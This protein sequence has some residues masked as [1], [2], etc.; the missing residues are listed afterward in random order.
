MTELAQFYTAKVTDFLK[1]VVCFDDKAEYGPVGKQRLFA[2]TQDDG[3]SESTSTSSSITSVNQRADN[4]DI[5]IGLNAQALTHAFAEKAILCSVIKPHGANEHI[6]NQIVSLGKTADVLILDWKLAERDASI[7]RDAVIK[8][9]DDDEKGGGRL[10]LIVLY[11]I[12]KGKDVIKELFDYL[13]ERGYS[14][15]EESLEIKNKHTLIVFYQK[16]GTVIPSSEVIEYDNLPEEIIKSFTTLTSGLLPAATL[17]AITAI[18][19]QTHHLLATFPS[20]LDGAFLAH[21]CLIPDPN[22]SEQFLL[23]ILEGEVGS[24]LRHSTVSESV[25]ITRCKTWIESQDIVEN[26]KRALLWAVDEYDF[27]K[28]D[29]LKTKLNL[30]NKNN[31]EIAEKVMA[32]LYKKN[33]HDLEAS[34]EDLSILA[35]ID[36]PRKNN[37]SKMLSVSHRLRLGSI[38]KDN[39]GKYLIC[40]QP[41]CDSLRLSNIENTEFPFLVLEAQEFSDKKKSLDLCI[42]SIDNTVVWLGVK[43][44]PKNI[45][46]HS[47]RAK[48]ASEAFVESTPTGSHHVF[49][50]Q[51]GLKFEW[52]AELKLGKAQRI[53]SLLAARIHTLGIDE[54][55]WMR[56]HQR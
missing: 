16:P 37:V 21:R 47:F 28:I 2:A 17:S 12:E 32:L 6:E 30:K 40:I 5:V 13:Q 22:D 39:Y 24:V 42:P 52:V 38:V 53:V 51:N 23:D 19:E 3:F 35:T 20:S 43:P 48:S 41:L 27:E 29:I 8:I 45:V 1:T 31:K 11:S 44:L 25:D 18:R 55:E 56:L 34:K 33:P 7:T 49:I 46:S 15:E 10:R 4:D 9:V 26:E 50:T 14:R 36:T 54:F